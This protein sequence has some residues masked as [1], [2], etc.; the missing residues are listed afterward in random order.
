MIRLKPPQAR[1]AVSP[2]RFR[3]LVAGRR[4]GKSYLANFE[5]LRAARKRGQR[6]MYL[7][8]THAQAKRICWVALKD[9]TRPF[10]ASRPSETDLRIEIKDGGSIVVRGADAYDSLRGEGFDLVV[11]D[12][13]ATMAP[14]VWTEVVRP[15]LADRLGRA[16]FIGTPKGFNHF[17]DLFKAAQSKP[18]W[19]TF[20]FTTEEGGNVPVAELQSAACDLNE[21]VY[22]QEY[23]ASFENLTS[24]RAYYAFESRDIGNVEF[25]P[26]SPLFWTL[27][28]NID[29]A[30]S[31]LCQIVDKRVIVLE[32][33]ALR[34]ASTYDVCN[35][36][37]RRAENYRGRVF[38][39]LRVRVYGDATGDSRRSS[40]SQTDWQIVKTFFTGRT[41]AYSARFAIPSHNPEIKDRVNNVNAVIANAEGRRRLTVAPGCLQLIRDLEQV[42]WKRDASGVAV[43]ELDHSDRLRTHMS[44]ALGY[45]ISSQLGIGPR[46]GLRPGSVC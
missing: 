35:E 46:S 36:F 42:C 14:E 17:Y 2:H 10:W 27:D 26:A 41:T 28:F 20:Q 23:K 37:A 15:S 22:R 30:C 21:R 45:F 13:Y 34:N 7:A 31:L 1:V 19:S 44:D 24:G 3:A 32:E 12:E 5:L 43:G 18:D 25:D 29:P 33:I 6:A 4:F 39:P 16:L 9:L 8:P 40:A 38:G 11:L